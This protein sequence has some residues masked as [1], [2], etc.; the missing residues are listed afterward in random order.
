MRRS[1]ATYHRTDACQALL[2]STENDRMPSRPAVRRRQG[3]PGDRP[4]T[5]RP[6][7]RPP[8]IPTGLGRR[9]CH[10]S[11]TVPTMSFFLLWITCVPV[12]VTVPPG[13]A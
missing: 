3:I 4:S 11:V 6:H 7:R 2:G 8:P 1:D 9:G 12:S 5:T 10:S 13:T